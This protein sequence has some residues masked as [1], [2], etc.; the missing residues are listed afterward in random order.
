M[1]DVTR[2]AFISSLVG[3]GMATGLSFVAGRGETSA[4]A[5]ARTRAVAAVPLR[6]AA[7]VGSPVKGGTLNYAEAGDFNDFNPWGFSAVNFEMYDQVFSRLLWKDGQGKEHPDLAESWEI[8]SDK[9]SI[10]LKLRTNAKWHDGKPCT[11]QDFV[12]MFGYLKDPAIGKYYGAQKIQGLMSPARDVRAADRFVL[13]LLFDKP[14]PYMTDILDYWFAVRIDDPSDPRFLKKLP[15]G[16]GPFKMTEWVANQYAKFT[17]F[18]EYSQKDLP[19]LNQFVFKRL[20]QAETLVPNLKSRAV[21]DILMSSL[22]D[23]APLQGDKSYAV[24][25]NENSGSVFNIIVNVRKPPF[26]KKGVRQALSYSL[27]RV[28]MAQAAFFG[29]SRPIT[30]PF[31]SPSSLAYRANLVMAHPFDLQKAG[32]LLER[33]GVRNLEMTINTTAAWPQMKLFCL[34]WQSDLA[35]IG[36]RLAVNEVENAQFYD[37]GGA[38]DLR[39]FALHPWINARTTRDPAIFFNTQYS[40]RGDE[41]NP[42]GYRNAQLEKLIADAAVETNVNRRRN[43]YQL[44]NEIVVDD[45]FM[46][47]VAT[48]P[49]IWGQTARLR[50]VDIDL[51]GNLF[52]ARTWFAA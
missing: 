49:R 24:V 36:V 20:A 46:I 5:P 14:V 22:A 44:A 6:A 21:D 32:S 37:I 2:R 16:T 43:L 10:R 51:N 7:A 42:Y 39:G 4:A 1:R 12:A 47:Q 35:K 48:N 17:R 33:A 40:Y 18:P 23:V 38:A 28:G 19:Y 15:V 27:N 13:E 30:S 52:L 29:V 41:R 9:R 50:D 11:A 3:T 8:A 34:I 26:D 25:S 45:C 31:Y